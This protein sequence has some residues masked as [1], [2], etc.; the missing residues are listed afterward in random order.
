MDGKT[1]LTTGVLTSIG[2]IYIRNELGIDPNILNGTLLIGGC[3]LGSLLPDIDIPGSM[4]GHLVFPLAIFLNNT[5]G[6]RTVTHS[7]LFIVLVCLIALLFGAPFSLIIGLAIGIV[8]H[9]VLDGITATGVPYLL[10]PF[11]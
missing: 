5:V 6:H 11:H 3:A 8:T 4:L 7:L 10:Y 2:L 1:H 9:L